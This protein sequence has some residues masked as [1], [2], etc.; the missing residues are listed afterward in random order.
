MLATS[1]KFLALLRVPHPVA[2]RA[3]IEQPERE[4]VTV[5][6]VGGS[7]T[8]DGSTASARTGSVTIPW[9][10]SSMASE[11]LGLDL[12]HLPFGA[13]MFLERGVRYADGST[14]LVPVG[15]LR[16]NAVS[17]RTSEGAATLDMSDRMAQLSDTLLR[18]YTPVGV[19]ASQLIEAFVYQV[20]GETIAYHIET[21]PGTEAVL[22][23]VTYEGDLGSA[24]AD[25]ATSVGAVALFDALG[26]FVLKPRVVEPADEGVW[27]IDSGAEG[28]FV[29]AN[30]SL[31]RTGAFSAVLVRGESAAGVPIEGFAY[32]LDEESPTYYL[33]P[34]GKVTSVHEA[35]SV[36]T[37]DQ[38]DELAMQLL[39]GYH[40]L[41]RSLAIQSVPNPALEVGDTVTLHF[42]DG[43]TELHLIAALTV[44][45]DTVSPTELATVCPGEAEHAEGMREAAALAAW[46][47]A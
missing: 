42:P 46:G 1:E 20:F 43:R 23:G 34:F 33:G 22:T 7:V 39:M 11:A 14:E 31:D 36:Q 26:D 37:Q 2:I 17:W 12:R 44:P 29:D 35:P 8:V 6:V 10:L 21:D 3:T 19:T 4:P 38:A 27:D 18:P 16:I 5:P 24:I 40:G 30:E 9:S 47:L 25:L 32:D 41:T 15:R 13:Y 45:L 28:V